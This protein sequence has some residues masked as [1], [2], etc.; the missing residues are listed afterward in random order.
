MDKIQNRFMFFANFAETIQQ[1]PEEKQP[2]AYKAIC[3]YGIFGKLPEDDL[4]KTICLMARASIFKEDGRKNNGGNHNPEGKNQHT[5]EVNSG[6]SRSIL[7]NSGQFLYKQK[8]KQK[9]ETEEETK[10]RKEKTKSECVCLGE[11]KNVKLTLDQ[12]K[13]LIEDYEWYFEDAIDALSSY[14]E[15]KGDKY[16]SHYAVLGKTNWVW[17]KVHNNPNCGIRP[18]CNMVPDPSAE[19]GI[20]KE[21][22]WEYYSKKYN[23]V[24]G[25][26]A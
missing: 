1:L 19:G 2:L 23:F 15:F 24:G 26:N 20:R 13:K 16:K 4:L 25:V 8:Q 17:E 12:I 11:F 21:T 22:A 9:Q 10:N 18:V 6:Q 5:K 14:L 3:E 7:V